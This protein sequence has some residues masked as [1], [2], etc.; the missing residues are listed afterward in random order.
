MTCII[1]LLDKGTLWMGGDSA[2]AAGS[3]LRISKISK[4]FKRSYK[5]TEY[6]IG[7]S[8]SARIRQIMEYE[9]EL[10][11]AM[12]PQQGKE[13]QIFV[14]QKFIPLLKAALEK[15]SFLQKK[16]GI[17]QIEDGKVLLGLNGHIFRIDN[18]FH[19]LE[20]EENFEAI[21]SGSS[22]AWGA[23]YA[24]NG[25]EAKARL[26]LAL[27]AAESATTNVQRPFTIVQARKYF[28]QS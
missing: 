15:N 11:Q 3:E 12:A 17:E 5:E 4:V 23:M 1:A 18:F 21:G 13:V 16:E 14:I 20:S 7:C 22:E 24:T 25:Q 8:G 2:I 27:Q 10:P 9:M 28:E 26:E 6:I 19:V